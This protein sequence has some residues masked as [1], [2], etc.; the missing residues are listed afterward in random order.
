[1]TTAPEGS[2]P[3]PPLRGV[4]R[5][6]M[7][8]ERVLDDALER[9]RARD[10]DDATIDV[11]A[12]AYG[13]GAEEVER[14]ARMHGV[15]RFVRTAAEAVGHDPERLLEPYGLAAGA[16][17]V[18]SL[19]GEVIAVKRVPSGTAVSYGYTYRTSGTSTLA[20]VGLGYA[21]GVPRLASSRAPVRVGTTV[22]VVAGRIA[23]DQF[24]VDLA[25]GE[26]SPGEDAVL[27][28]DADGLV[29][30]A[31]AAERTPPALTA[32]LGRRI[33]RQWVDR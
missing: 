19:V 9:M 16:R 2:R 1:M 11:R 13:H 6:A 7:L 33:R 22:G 18:L 17:P 26:A 15:L 25:D 28:D 12:D 21:D 23:M 5:V 27:W 8:T 3:E 20:L 10:G 29:A 14:R 32:G 24:V 31:A 30:W 4:R